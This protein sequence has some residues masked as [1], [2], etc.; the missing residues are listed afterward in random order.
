MNFTNIKIG[1]TIK[2]LR[3]KQNLS[4]EQLASVTGVSIQAVSKWETGNSLPD[5][6][7]LPEIAAFF[8]VSLDY[9]FFGTESG[10]AKLSLP[11]DGVLR[12]VQ[13]LGSRILQSDEIPQE[14]RMQLEIA[15]A[16]ASSLLSRTANE[17]TIHVEIHGNA[18]ING[19]ISGDAFAGYSTECRSISGSTSTGGS[20]DC[21]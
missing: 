19:D 20:A 3:K 12:I 15:K 7:L 8:Q 16:A 18:D 13:C 11:D 1:E 9:L 5:T 14:T 4:Q 2:A 6:I 10:N 21:T 17:Q